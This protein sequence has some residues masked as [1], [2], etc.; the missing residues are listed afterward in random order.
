[1]RIV[2][3]ASNYEDTYLV[4][5]EDWSSEMAEAGDHKARWYEKMR[6][7]GL[8]VKLALDEQGRAIGMIQY[9][10]IE[11]TPALGSGLYMIL[12]I[13]V[14]GHKQGVG[15]R[16]GHGVGRSL[17]AAAEEDV[18]GRGAKGIVTWGLM[19]PFWMKAS[20]F[21]KHGYRR[22]DR[23]GMRA[24]LW[25]PFTPD[26]VP[27]RWIE[28]GPPPE[29]VPNKVAVT[30]FV[31]GWCPANNI[32][33]ERVRRAVE[34]FGEDVVL[35][36]IDTSERADMVRCGQSDCI[37][38]DGKVLQKGPPLRYERIH[39]RIARRVARLQR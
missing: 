35:T 24:L 19:L 28:P 31:N 32:V 34:S 14:H 23:S 33:Y 3:L 22:V 38:L 39:K 2:D 20:W 13:W 11:H 4:C 8:G 5:L 16:Q 30:A 10:P 1:M 15:D 37:F 12:C 6:E 9:L 25:K 26:A 17:L 29:R 21:R 36:S 7:R 27:P 18:R